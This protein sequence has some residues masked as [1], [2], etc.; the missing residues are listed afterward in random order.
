MKKPILFT[1]LASVSAL[2]QAPVDHA[3]VVSSAAAALRSQYVD[4][5]LGNEMAQ[6]IESAASSGAYDSIP[7]PR[8]F[9]DRLTQDLQKV[10][11]D[12][13]VRVSPPGGRGGGGGAQ[14]L[15][16]G[17]GAGRGVFSNVEL[18]DGKV[19]IF[20]LRSFARPDDTT[21]QEVDEAFNK[22]AGARALVFDLRPSGGGSPDMVEYVCSY[23]FESGS[24]IHLTDLYAAAIDERHE[25]WTQP[26]LPG[27]HF[28]GVPV[29]ILTAARTVSAAEGFAYDLQALKRALVVGE[30]TRGAANASI[31]SPIEAGF[32]ITVPVA[33][34]I[35]PVT[36]TSWENTGVIPDIPVPAD[37]ALDRALLEL[38]KSRP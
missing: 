12:Q 6:A 10:S 1:L 16:G 37:E 35:N 31:V 7:A 26:D 34:V 38:Q 27:Q 32:S 28:P 22:V 5:K 8:D 11:H 21:K 33:Y 25:S 17:G 36:K 19:G 30:K 4:R 14:G 20:T 3:K 29:Y 15:T 18:R 2:A 24:R 13:H 9:A 23:L